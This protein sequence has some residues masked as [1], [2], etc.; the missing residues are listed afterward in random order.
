MSS[1]NHY[2]EQ[3]PDN[4]AFMV[5]R[6]KI[7]EDLI[8][9][10]RESGLQAL[11]E[12][13]K[14]RFEYV[15]TWGGVPIVRLPEDIMLQ[16]ELIFSRKFKQIIEVGVARGGGMLFSADMQV[17]SGVKGL[18]IGIDNR[19]HEHTRNALSDSKNKESLLLIEGDSTSSETL[20]KL[21][22]LIDRFEP[23]LVVLDSDHTKQHV[24]KEL[25][26]YSRFLASGSVIIVCDTV[27]DE[28]GEGY[29]PD[30][31]WNDGAGPMSAVSEFLENE[32][33]WHMLESFSNRGELSSIRNGVIEKAEA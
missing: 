5:M 1:S 11:G 31:P 7:I 30:R 25:H 21:K 3:V 26:I 2:H 33:D 15:W 24:L 14:A 8:G 16:Q 6:E 4:K 12:L 19:I 22:N 13:I 20:E 28:L 29:F 10:D 27:I 17:I 18:V 23:T 9:R 32:K